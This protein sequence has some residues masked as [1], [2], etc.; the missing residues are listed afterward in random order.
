[1]AYC[2]S[3]ASGTLDEGEFEP[4]K[5]VEFLPKSLKDNLSII[6]VMISDG[7]NKVEYDLDIFLSKTYIYKE[8]KIRFGSKLFD[9]EE[10]TFLMGFKIVLMDLT[11]I[12]EQ[13]MD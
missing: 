3:T 8:K 1:V 12:T 2:L 6:S 10:L 11:E 13:E 4:G 9:T 5:V 7:V